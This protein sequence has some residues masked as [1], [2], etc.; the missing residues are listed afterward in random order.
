MNN[1]QIFDSII[2][3]YEKKYSFYPTIDIQSF[4][5]PEFNIIVL[6]V[7]RWQK[8]NHFF[9]FTLLHEIGHCETFKKNQKQVTREY[10]ASQWAINEFN[11]LGLNL[12][13]KDRDAWQDYIYS[14]TKAKNKEKYK[15]DWNLK[16][17]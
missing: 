9:I 4:A 13:K 2:L 6:D 14:F 7:K 11:K 3:H 1:K 10:L 12:K 16:G 5:I 17:E 15:L 8:P